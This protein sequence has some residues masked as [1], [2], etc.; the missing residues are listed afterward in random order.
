M[1]D[2]SRL[3]VRLLALAA[4][5]GG[6]GTKLQDQYGVQ[7]IGPVNLDYLAEAR[8]VVLDV[9]G[10]ELSRTSIRP[11]EPFALTGEGINTATTMSGVIRLRALDGSGA[12]V[13]Y[14]QSPELELSLFSYNLRVFVQKPGTFGQALP[15]IN[16]IRNLVAVSAPA[17]PP[18][19]SGARPITVGYFGMGRETNQI[20]IPNSTMTMTVE[21]PSDQ[22]YIYN[23]LT[24]FTDDGGFG[25]AVQGVRQPR[26][27]PA[28]LVR[29]DSSIYVFGGTVSTMM[30]QAHQTSQLDILR[31]VRP[32]FDVFEQRVVASARTTD[33]PGVARARSVLA[34]AD[35]IYAFGGEADGNQLDTVVAI[36]PAM[37]DA[38]K[39]L[40]PHMGAPRVGHTATVVTVSAVPEVLVFGGDQSAPAVAEV[41]VPGTMPKFLKPD[42]DPG[43]ARWNHAAILLPPDRILVVGGLGAGGPFG[44]SL[45]YS[46]A[47]RQIAR[48]P[49]TL[50]TP[51]SSFSTFI[52]GND[53]VIAGGLD[54][55][56]Q[57]I[58]NAEVFNAMDDQLMPRGVVPAEKRSG[59]A[60]T[61]LPNE[62]ALVIG[63]TL[64]DGTASRVVEIYQPFR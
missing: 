15:A 47:Q 2:G 39:L 63:G 62:S 59:A 23:P 48:G 26:V 9:G 52:V 31:V 7:I 64:P 32:N 22:F 24:H 25:G 49:I 36:D 1:S 20:Q 13:A 55:Q 8:T 43:P 10:K 14:G 42:G 56:G 61:V 19:G 5:L 37:D 30:I 34:S 51:R 35:V 28:A 44:D 4:L 60:V 40:E 58:G 45:I 6:C 54:A 17:A 46:A 27:D 50:R 11:G 18:T 33:K 3:G 29:Q 41:F 53:L 38:F 21:S 57:P 12:L 16:P